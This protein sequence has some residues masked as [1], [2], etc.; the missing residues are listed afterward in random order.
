[1]LRRQVARCAAPPIQAQV[2]SE[3]QKRWCTRAPLTGS[4]PRSSGIVPD[5]T[6]PVTVSSVSR[7]ADQAPQTNRP[8]KTPSPLLRYHPNDLP[9]IPTS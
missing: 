6:I 2:C 4:P 1:V 7:N 3:G 5:K 8:R 9:A